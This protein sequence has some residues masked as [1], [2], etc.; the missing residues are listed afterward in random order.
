MTDYWGNLPA[1]LPLG[2]ITD[3]GRP[4]WQGFRRDLRDQFLG[5][6]EGQENAVTTRGLAEQFFGSTNARAVQKMG[7]EL[8]SLRAD[9][10]V[11]SRELV[12]LD[13]RWWVATRPEDHLRYA[14]K[15]VRQIKARLERTGRR[16]A[17]GATAHPRELGAHPALGM[18]DGARVAVGELES[19]LDPDGERTDGGD[20]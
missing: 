5:E 1:P 10:E 18:I 9:L 2:Y 13:N 7:Q 3:D 19:S 8:D 12:N 20:D 11:D 4:D 14:N 15:G 6:H 16:L 17:I